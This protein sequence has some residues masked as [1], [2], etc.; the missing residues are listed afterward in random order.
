LIE[1]TP[2]PLRVCRVSFVARHVMRSPTGD[3]AILLDVLSTGY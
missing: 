3:A 2:P 1:T